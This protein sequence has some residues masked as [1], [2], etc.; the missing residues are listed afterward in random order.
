M[1][2]NLDSICANMDKDPRNADIQI[3]CLKSLFQA[4]RDEKSIEKYQQAFKSIDNAVKANSNNDAVILQVLNLFGQLSSIRTLAGK[5]EATNIFTQL[6]HI[7][8]LKK[9]DSQIS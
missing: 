6:I 1:R 5:L 4:L 2:G 7:L 3:S 9:E 8:N